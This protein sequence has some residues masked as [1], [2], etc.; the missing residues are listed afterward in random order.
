MRV[1][2]HGGPG[3]VLWSRKEQQVKNFALVGA[4][5]YIAPRHLQAIHDTG[6]RLV[7]A[8]DPHDSVGVIDRY[9]HDA[10]F[11]T[12]IERF[13]RHL[14]RL[15]REKRPERVDFLTV[16]SPNY[17]H[18]A[19]CRLGLRVH[20]DVICEKPLTNSPWNIDGLAEL[21]EEFGRHI[22][23]VLQLRLLPVLGR[24]K[25]RLERDPAR[26]R[27]SLCLTYVTRRGPWYQTSWKGDPTKSGGIATN[28]G[29]HLFD[30]LLWLFGRAGRSDVHFRTA[31]KMAGFL[32][33]EW[34]D[35]TWLLSVDKA[36][37]PEGY[38]AA[39]KGAYRSLTMNGEEIEFSEN[40][41]D[42][43]TQ[44]YR[45]I[46]SGRGCGI[47]DARPSVELAYAIRTA[48]VVKSTSPMHP[49]LERLR[50]M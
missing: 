20:A 26:R 3:N 9:F 25:E 10:R 24:L 34:A 45:E 41:T 31:E 44:V 23:T 40:F 4:A 14:E 47:G 22:Y 18:D 16:C 21:E 43:H 35:V 17:L 1:G 7:A 27:A 38:L 36:D 28:I 33:L 6:N 42:L 49:N 5:G 37:L 32:E 2:R 12:E 15:R 11:F 48:A 13:D 19:H 50:A 39:G 46:L 8:T 30:L 29:V